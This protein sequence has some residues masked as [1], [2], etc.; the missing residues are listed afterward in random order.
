MTLEEL[1]YNDKIEKSRIANNLIDFE[2]ARVVAEHKE[3]YIVK[4]DKGELEA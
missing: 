4:T 2:I 1:G 3:R